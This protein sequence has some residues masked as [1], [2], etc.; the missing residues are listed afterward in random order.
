MRRK[1]QSNRHH[2]VQIKHFIAPTPNKIYLV[3]FG[4]LWHFPFNFWMDG[5]NVAAKKFDSDRKISVILDR[6]LAASA[7]Q[8]VRITGYFLIRSNWICRINGTF[9]IG[10][11]VMLAPWDQVDLLKHW[12]IFKNSFSSSK[13]EYL[14]LHSLFYPNN[15]KPGSFYQEMLRV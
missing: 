8:N 9:L 11:N 13:M 1:F 15:L 5:F 2:Y 10:S 4:K 14:L 6:T 3:S 12:T 7:V